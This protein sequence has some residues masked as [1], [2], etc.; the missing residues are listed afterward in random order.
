VGQ[1]AATLEVRLLGK[2][3]LVDKARLPLKLRAVSSALTEVSRTRLKVSARLS[4]SVQRGQLERLAVTLPEGFDVASVT[5]SDLGWEVS[6]GALLLTPAVPVEKTL[7]VG[8]ELTGE[9]RESFSAP[10]LVPRAVAQVTLLTAVPVAADGLPEITDVGA[11]R[12]AAAAEVPE[13]LR[14]KGPFFLVRDP[15]RPPRWSVTW[16]QETK[17][18]AAQVDRLV[19]NVVYGLAERAA[20]EVW[21]VV[22]SSGSTELVLKPPEGLELLAVE[23]N[24]TDVQPGVAERGLVIP[25]AAG[26]GAQVIHVSGLLSVGRI[27]PEG[28]LSI[29]IPS[30]SAPVA[31]VE[32][33]ASLPGGRVYE[34]AEEDRRS[35]RATVPTAVTGPGGTASGLELLATRAAS[36][37][38]GTSAPFADPT[39][40]V[41]LEAAWSALSESP[42]PL[43]IHVK[44]QRQKEEWF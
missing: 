8:V 29:P 39:G 43:V 14:A 6:E 28:D 37:A 31:R 2:G 38:H 17:V 5:P 42:G 34:L 23:R 32:V 20:Y 40:A 24:R 12:K 21:A 11:S 26:T 27:P 10:L 13:E 16:S 25:L 19:V 3:R 30:L 36:A 9:A 44:P 1:P 18:L 35:G 7:D 41:G 15:Q 33:H 22:R 4:L